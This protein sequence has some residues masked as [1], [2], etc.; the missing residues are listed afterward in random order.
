MARSAVSGDARL[1]ALAG[2]V[3]RLSPNVRVLA[4]FATTADCQL[5]TVG[6]TARVDFDGLLTGTTFAAP[7]GQSPFAF[8]RG[9]TFEESLRR[10]GHAPLLGL[11][12]RKLGFDI[13]D[14][15]VASMREAD[16]GRASLARRARATTERVRQIVHRTPDAPN[17]LDGAVLTRSVAGVRSYFE[18]DALAARFDEPIRAGEIK[19]F[20]TIDGQADP[21]KVG[22]A[23]AQVAI[24]ILLLEELVDQVGGDADAL[25]SQEALLITPRDTGLQPTMCAKRVHWE[26][27]RARRILDAAPDAA[28]L[29]DSLPDGLPTFSAVAD[30]T[31]DPD[32]RLEAAER[33]ADAVGTAYKPACLAACGMARFCRHRAHDVGDPAVVGGQLVRLVPGVGSVDRVAELADGAQASDAEAPVA[34]QLTRAR[35]LLDR[36]GVS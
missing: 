12:R 34:A 17:L 21:E 28:E 11:L 26:V 33:L 20:P 31:A 4:R 13:T 18:A 25:V 14:A 8:R 1:D 19:S 15:R 16:W 30:T 7:Y 27:R 24:Y 3:K 29:A 2:G 9:N 23:M 35:R 22:A 6:F 5:A 32:A 10:D 36:Y